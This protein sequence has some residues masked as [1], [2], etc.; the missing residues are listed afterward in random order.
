MRVMYEN[1][2]GSRVVS[3]AL[4]T[5]GAK[6]GVDAI[7]IRV[8]PGDLERQARAAV[9]I[10]TE[11]RKA[12][13]NTDDRQNL[14]ATLIARAL[15]DGVPREDIKI[16]FGEEAPDVPTNNELLKST[17]YLATRGNPQ[18]IIDT[19]NTLSSLANGG[20]G[21]ALPTGSTDEP[22]VDEAGVPK[23]S[24]GRATIVSKTPIK[25]E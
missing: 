22:G 2:D 23:P 4:A 24:K 21:L 16:I 11:L 18:N 20:Q 17:S 15:S 12:G 3:R 7:P 14:R 10:E 19:F 9:A 13:V 8:D 6:T 5:E 1:P 25:S